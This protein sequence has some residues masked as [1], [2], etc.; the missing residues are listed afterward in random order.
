MGTVSSAVKETVLDLLVEVGQAVQ[1][2]DDRLLLGGAHWGGARARAFAAA[3]QRSVARFVAAQLQCSLGLNV[4]LGSVGGQVGVA[5]SSG[6]GDDVA[7][8]SA[9]EAAV[10]AELLQRIGVHVQVVV[11]DDVLG[12]L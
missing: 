9:A 10:E 5:D 2:G 11:E 8:A 6:N 7:S 3:A 4:Q 1:L 12:R